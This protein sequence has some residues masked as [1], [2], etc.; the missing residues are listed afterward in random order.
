MHKG[1]DGAV[2][3]PGQAVDTGWPNPDTVSDTVGLN[4]GDPEGTQTAADAGW[5]H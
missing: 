5:A 4:T 1:G 3:K 2:F